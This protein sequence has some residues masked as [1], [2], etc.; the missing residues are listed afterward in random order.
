MVGNCRITVFVSVA[1]TTD[2]IIA[3][4]ADDQIS[5]ITG[6]NEVITIG[7]TGAI[8]AV[9]GVV[10][11]ETKN[12]VVTAVTADDVGRAIASDCVTVGRAIHVFKTAIT[13]DSGETGIDC[14]CRIGIKVDRYF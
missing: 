5:S 3:I 11:G 14:C 1:T 2:E 13:R 8:T 10:V 6:D 7:T 12:R 9:D 4:G